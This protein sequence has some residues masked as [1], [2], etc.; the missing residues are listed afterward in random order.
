MSHYSIL[1]FRGKAGKGSL[2]LGRLP[3]EQLVPQVFWIGWRGSLGHN[4]G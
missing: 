2:Y 3:R 1:F 4:S